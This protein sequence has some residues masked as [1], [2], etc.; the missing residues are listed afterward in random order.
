MESQTYGKMLEDV[1][2]IVRGLS[3]GNIDLD[4]M[5]FEVERGYG[6]IKTMRERLQS[7]RMKLE[8]LRKDLDL[9]QE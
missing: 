6:L 8:E 2:D 1:E 3:S 9:K 7:T 4:R 5:V